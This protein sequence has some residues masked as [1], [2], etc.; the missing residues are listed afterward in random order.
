[1]LCDYYNHCIIVLKS[2]SGD[3]CTLRWCGLI[4]LIDAVDS[5]TLTHYCGNAIHMYYCI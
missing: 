4:W 1:M 5:I 3:L 2:L